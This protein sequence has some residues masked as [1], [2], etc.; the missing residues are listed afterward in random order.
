MHHSGTCTMYNV[1]CTLAF[2]CIESHNCIR[3]CTIVYLIY[4]YTIISNIN[5]NILY[6]LIYYSI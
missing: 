1:H 4:K 3:K 2:M 5:Y 6:S